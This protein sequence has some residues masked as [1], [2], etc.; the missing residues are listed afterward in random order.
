MEYEEGF[1]LH[2]TAHVEPANVDKYLKYFKLAYEAVIAEPE[3]TFFEVYQSS[4]N[5]GELHLVE[6]RGVLDPLS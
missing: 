2:V 6:N 4:K 3:C 1:S 5:P